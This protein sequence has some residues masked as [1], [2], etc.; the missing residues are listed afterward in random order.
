MGP[1]GARGISR[2]Y[3]GAYEGK[4]RVNVHKL[5]YG[6]SVVQ[7]LAMSAATTGSTNNT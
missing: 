5:S 4:N 2:D 3:R 6:F 7:R 1:L